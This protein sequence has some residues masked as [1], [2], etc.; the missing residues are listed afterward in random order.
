[1][2][3]EY[4]NE[5]EIHKYFSDFDK[6]IFEDDHYKKFLYKE[7]EVMGWIVIEENYERILIE[8]LY[9]IEEYRNQKIATKL[10]NYV[11]S[12]ARYNKLKSVVVNTSKDNEASNKF[13]KKFGF[14]K[15]GEV[16][17]LYEHIPVS[18]FYKIKTI[19]FLN[20]K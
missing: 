3:V 11:M 7:D 14:E 13:Y 18:V 1:M 17:N 12:I 2:I 16:N 5:N 9:V 19:N 6:Q 20:R 15:I 4:N 8:W 10:L